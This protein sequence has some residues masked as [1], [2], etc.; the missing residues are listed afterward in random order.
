MCPKCRTLYTASNIKDIPINF[1]LESVL[2]LLDI[3]KSTKANDLP[4]CIEHLL[5]VSHRCSTHKAWICKRC[6]REDHSMQSCKIISVSDELD[7]KKAMQVDQSNPL[8]NTFEETFTKS[9]DCKNLYKQLL[10]ECDEDVIRYEKMTKKLQEKCEKVKKSRK[11]IEERYENF[12]QMLDKQ[13]FKKRVFD[14]AVT[15]LRSSETIREVARCS[16]EVQTEA[17][18]LQ[19][20]S[21]EIEKEIKKEKELV[22]QS[23]KF[24]DDH[25]LGYAEMSVRNGKPH[26]H[27]L[28]DIDSCKS[29]PNLLI[30]GE[31]TDGILT[32]MDIAWPGR[33]P[34]RVY[35]KMLGNTARARQ[36]LL[37]VTGQCGYS[38][39]GLTF[40]SPG[41][42]GK[43]GEY[44]V[45]HPYDGKQGAPLL[46]DFTENDDI[47]HDVKAGHICGTGLSC[48]NSALFAFRL[49]DMP[50]NTSNTVFGKVT[51]GLE[52]LHDVA[53]SKK[54]RKIKVVDCGVVLFG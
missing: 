24:K 25:M 32:F 34:R 37:L 9:D 39:I 1:S 53:K 29:S 27:S 41:N 31:N 18:K 5:Q 8:L 22:L 48:Y 35:M 3:S 28:Q 17:E 21:Q 6:V 43:P 4:E 10:K 19:L 46:E 54:R 49:G 38:Y 16:V 12:G 36:H 52:I 23:F 50:G 44:I 40:Y 45:L 20:V 26:V 2:N 7:I 14:K 13:K 51:S 30:T 47:K 42:K 15:S 11:Q 33:E